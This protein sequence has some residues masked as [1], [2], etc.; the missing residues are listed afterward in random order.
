MN[1]DQET[2]NN[3]AFLLVVTLQWLLEI[4]AVQKNV[5]DAA[6]QTLEAG[7]FD[8]VISLEGASRNRT[9]SV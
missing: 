6:E 5:M 8:P 1:V 9:F 3:K 7:Q 4:Q 2:L